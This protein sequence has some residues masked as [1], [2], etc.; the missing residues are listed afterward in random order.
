M[1]A[2]PQMAVLRLEVRE[3]D[4]LQKDDM[5]GQACIPVT[6]LKLGVRSVALQSRKGE[7]RTSKLLC[8][9]E[10]EA[11]KGGLQSLNNVAQSARTKIP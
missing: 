10:L 5:V 9:F 11:L 7:P 3:H 6:E 2:V 1:S 8:H 4:Q